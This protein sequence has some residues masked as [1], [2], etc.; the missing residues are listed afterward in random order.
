ML[1]R[2]TAVQLMMFFEGT[3]TQEV[4]KCID[5]CMALEL[6][7]K[8][9]ISLLLRDLTYVSEYPSRILFNQDSFREIIL[10]GREW[11]G[12]GDKAEDSHVS[13]VADTEHRI[14][15]IYPIPENNNILL[16]F[17]V[18]YEGKEL[19]KP[20]KAS[21][22]QIILGRMKDIIAAPYS[23]D[24]RFFCTSE[25]MDPYFLGGDFYEIQ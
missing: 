5:T 19:I 6:H 9:R 17:N 21:D 11:I 4:N 14:K 25:A 12:G 23:F 15:T 24:P 3:I 22:Y 18:Y 13:L 10:F 2:F 20:I 8:A 16:G 7:D 1:T